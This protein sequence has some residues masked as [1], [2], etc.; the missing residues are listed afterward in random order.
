DWI[1]ACHRADK[2]FFCYL[3]TNAPHSPYNVDAKYAQLYLDKG[4][5]Q[6]MANFYGMIAN[7]DENIGKLLGKL[8]EWKLAENTIV[9]FMTDN[10]SAMG[11]L[12]AAAARKGRAGGVSPLIPGEKAWLG[13]NAGMRAQKGSQYEGGHR[14]PCF[15]RYP[16]RYSNPGE[17]GHLMA[18]FELL[19]LLI[20]ICNLNDRPEG[21]DGPFASD[22]PMRNVS[23]A[24]V[25]HSQRL[26]H[27]EKWRKTAVLL[28]KEWCC[29][30]G[31][32]LYNL[33]L[34]PGQNTDVAAEN[35]KVLKSLTGFYDS[36]WKYVSKRFDEY[37]DIPLGDEHA[38]EQEL[39]CH[40][41]H[42][43]DDKTPPW[44]QS[45]QDG[46]AK[47][48]LVNGQWAVE[49]TRPGRYAFTLRMR[50]RGVPYKIPAG[51]ARV[52]I[53]DIE[54]AADIPAVSDSVTITLDLKPTGHVMLQTWLDKADGKSR[55]AYYTTVKRLD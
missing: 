12:P 34:D 23:K 27:P 39:C 29:I 10:G 8:D 3:A 22:L 7:I 4:V 49:V 28:E 55:G 43:V 5:P 30:D 14:V 51:K 19:P 20:S 26:D 48:P 21:L 54:A 33:R 41:W 50:P 1:D 2:P 53:G 45:G 25:V 13:F 32:E 52:K 11:V 42:P 24:I 36:W 6:P 17:S 44:N 18:H 31:K 15:I 9:V 16:R 35:P 46:V 47:D 38:P 37:S 40:D